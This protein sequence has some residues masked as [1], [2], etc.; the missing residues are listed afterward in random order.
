M[1]DEL[2][3]VCD[4]NNNIVGQKMKSLILSKGLWHRTARLFVY[5]PN[6]EILIQLRSANKDLY[7]NRWD[8]GA[9]GHVSAGESYEDAAIREAG[10]ELGMF[11]QKNDLELLQID[12]Y[13]GGYG[14]FTEKVFAA[15]YLVRFEG[16]LDKFALQEK[17]VQELKFIFAD[18]LAVDVKNY[19]EKYSPH[20]E[21][22]WSIL[23]DGVKKRTSC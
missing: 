18:D 14:K 16:G 22:Y 23:V 3:D 5:N 7:P 4:E 2:M 21:S 9:A 1:E 19:P 10:E 17:E 13:E 15:T 6:G 8:V 11:F 20:P 12:K